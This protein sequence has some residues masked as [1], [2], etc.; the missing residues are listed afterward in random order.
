MRVQDNVA[1]SKRSVGSTAAPELGTAL[2]SSSS[3]DDSPRGLIQILGASDVVTLDVITSE[4]TCA[5]IPEVEAKTPV[6]KVPAI[7]S[8]TALSRKRHFAPSAR[9]RCDVRM[10]L[11]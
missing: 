10:L 3:A 1:D 7:R 9:S 11:E 4:E 8:L 2:L 6:R 5:G